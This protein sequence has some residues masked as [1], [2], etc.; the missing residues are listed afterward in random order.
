[1][2][3]HVTWRPSAEQHLAQLWLNAIDRNAMTIAANTIDAD[4]AQDPLAVGESRS[5]A[6]RIYIV[7]P[8]AVYYTVDVASHQVAVWA[9]WCRRGP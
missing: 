9:V 6:T 8:L 5:G 4:L 1:M 3:Y 7:S 2:S